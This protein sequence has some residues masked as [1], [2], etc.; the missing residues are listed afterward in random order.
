[1]QGVCSQDSDCSSGLGLACSSSKTCLS[2]L[3]TIVIT[4]KLHHI[5]KHAN[6]QIVT[7]GHWCTDNTECASGQ[8]YENSCLDAELSNNE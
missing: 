1:M 7:T 8:C 5:F 6:M 4:F 3:N 2:N